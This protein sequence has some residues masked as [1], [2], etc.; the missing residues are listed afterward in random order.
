MRFP[1]R[2]RLLYACV[3]VCACELTV[4]AEVLGEG[5]SHEELEALGDEVADGPGV[6]VQAAGGEALVG[7]VE[8]DEQV[9]PLGDTAKSHTLE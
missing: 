3:R 6:F 9:P 8:E 1:G 7:R 2:H 4:E 5:L